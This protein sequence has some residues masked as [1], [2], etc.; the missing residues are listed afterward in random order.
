MGCAITCSLGQAGGDA[1]LGSLRVWQLVAG[2]SRYGTA[3]LMEN[4]R[5]EDGPLGT[6]GAGDSSPVPAPRWKGKPA[7][8]SASSSSMKPPGS[9]VNTIEGGRQA[10]PSLTG[11]ETLRR[12]W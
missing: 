11:R 3:M 4:E 1:A 2:F 12:G 8:R 10:S 7:C 6:G 9:N 5:R